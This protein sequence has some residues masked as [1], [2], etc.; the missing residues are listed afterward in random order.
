[1]TA[2]RP[3]LKVVRDPTHVSLKAV[4]GALVITTQRGSIHGK[5]KDDPLSEGMRAKNIHLVDNP[6]AAG[7]WVATT[8]VT[9]FA[10]DTIYQQAGL[11]VYEDDD[12]Y[13]KWSY[14]FNWQAGKGQG[15][16]LVAETAGATLVHD[17]PTE[18]ASGLKK[19]WLRA[20]ELR[21][22]VRALLERGRKRRTA[23]GER[24]W[25]GSPKRVGLIAKNGGNKEAPEVDVAFEFFELRPVADKK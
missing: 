12:N 17:R 10:P 21:G 1:M 19:A 22:Q 18:N 14:E 5:E 20:H 6:L 9:G 13:L 23:A 25:A 11:I 24:A 3:R 7:D 4:P 16:I 15:F 8:C 2:S